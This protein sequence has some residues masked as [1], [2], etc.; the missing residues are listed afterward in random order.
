[1]NINKINSALLLNMI[2]MGAKNLSNHRDFVNKLNVFPVPDGDTGTNMNLSMGSGLKEMMV[3]QTEELPLIL[4]AFIRGLLMGARGNSGV[5]LSQLFRGFSES[6]QEE[7]EINSSAFAAALN[8]GVK[9]AYQSVTNPVEGTILTVAKDAA[10]RAYEVAETEDDL[11]KLMEEIVIEAKQ[12]LERTPELL[13]IL[14]EVGVVDSGGKGLVVIYEGFLAALKGDELGNPDSEIDIETMVQL[15][16]E[17][18][19]QSFISADSIEYGYCTEFF[20]E[21][22]Q[23]NKTSFEET[24]FRNQLS[25]YG[26]S[27]LVASDA[28]L[29]KIH[30]HTEYPGK[31]MNLAQAYGDLVNIDIENMRKQYEK[32]V[33]NEQETSS[34]LEKKKFGIIAVASGEG[35]KEMFTSLGTTLIIEGGQT[36]NPSTED[37]LVAVQ[38]VNAEYTFI[39]PN[40]KNIVL[41]ANQVKSLSEQNIII[42]PT[43]SIP[44]GIGALF[45]FDSE[46]SIEENEENMLDG[47]QNVKTASVTYA[48]RDTIINNMEIKQGSYMGL[49]EDTILVTNPD[50][51]ETVKDLLEKIVDEDDEI[52]TIFYG[53]DVSE[54]EITDLE[55]YVEEHLEDVEI[56][57]HEGDQPIYSF[58][59]MVE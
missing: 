21:L 59:I 28:N 41:A 53:V 50:K 24:K 8:N 3:R 4:S 33:N 40:N 36:M 6:L 43:K 52:V 35:L 2:Q 14:K 7:T 29:V 30:I 18:S 25:E 23:K 12:S 1:M 19:A 48:I 55:K 17:R 10:R 13:P 15:E 42:I 9:V 20:V 37:L 11:V 38:K 45:A 44:Q 32:I 27:L 57:L 22:D 49:N 56:E 39:L 31:V 16:H 51:I 58:I 47:M 26:D 5:I 34:L 54:K 46:V